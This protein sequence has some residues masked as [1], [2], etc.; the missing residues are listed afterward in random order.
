MEAE[1]ATGARGREGR[2]TTRD[3]GGSGPEA[4]GGSRASPYREALGTPGALGFVVP[5]F[6][7]RLSIAMVGL[8]IVLLVSD[9]TGSY[10]T[11]GG[12]AATFALAQALGGP[13]LG[14]AVDRAGQRRVLVP[15]TVVH[16]VAMLALVAAAETGAPTWTLFASAAVS[17]GAFLAVGAL[18]RARWSHV[19]RH[20]SG[21][22]DAAYAVE[23]VADE[24]T[25]VV[26][27]VLVTA[28]STGVGRSVGLLVALACT[29]AGSLV[30][31]RHRRSEPP[32]APGRQA[33]GSWAIRR[34]A[35]LAV[36]LVFGGAGVV[37]AGAEVTVVAFAE[38][39]GRRADAGWVLALIALGSMLAALAYGTRVWRTSPARRFAVGACL[40]GAGT[41]LMALSP[42]VPVLAGAAFVFGLGVSPTVIPGFALVARHAPAGR[43]T[44]AMAWVITTLGLGLAAGSSVA[45]HTVDLAGPGAALWVLAVAGV[46]T[47]LTAVL[48]LPV[49]A[50]ADDAAEPLSA[51]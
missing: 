19:L 26:G 43:L 36:A 23:S 24:V 1:H 12:V 47:G 29:V 22:L 35:V 18:V 41:V 50:R 15:A 11:A 49:T 46:L 10:G 31:A 16:A 2:V 48:T 6:V 5:G 39:A 37:F 7:G 9:V 38:D 51:P 20:R 30:L 33:T 17:G 8:G 34:P 27:P 45:G 13:L 40:F 42:S 3:G 25:F 4:V 28:L 21:T 14:R 32:A 44:E